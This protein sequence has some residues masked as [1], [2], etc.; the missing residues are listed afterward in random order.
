MDKNSVAQNIALTLTTLR[1]DVSDQPMALSHKAQATL[2][3]YLADY[4]D[5][6]KSAE[7]KIAAEIEKM[8]PAQINHK[9]GKLF[10]S[11]EWKEIAAKYFTGKIE[12]KHVTQDLPQEIKVLAEQNRP[13]YHLHSPHLDAAVKEVK[14]LAHEVAELSRRL[15]R[16]S[17]DHDM[18][19][20][21]DVYIDTPKPVDRSK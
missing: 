14:H 10:S 15:T 5:T 18:V 2:N 7:K 12:S 6:S 11:P 9:F 8:S 20:P 4:K 16:T 17:I 1:E 13:N 21:T 19:H 3:K